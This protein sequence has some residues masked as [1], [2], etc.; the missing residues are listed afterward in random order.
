METR[1]RSLNGAAGGN[2]A[3][4]HGAGNDRLHVFLGK[5]LDDAS[6]L[7]GFAASIIEGLTG[8]L[9]PSDATLAEFK[10]D[11]KAHFGVKRRVKP[12]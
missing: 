6:Y 8:G 7:L 1:T 10:R 11:Y 5:K 4:D 12:R 3:D 9:P 2:G